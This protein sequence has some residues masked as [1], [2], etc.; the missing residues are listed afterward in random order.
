MPRIA[1]MPFSIFVLLIA[2]VQGCG[3]SP[4][5]FAVAERAPRS[6]KNAPFDPPATYPEWA[7]DQPRYMRPAEE[8]VPEPK[9]NANDPLHYFTK[10]KVVMVRKPEGYD[11]EESPRVALWWTDN[12]GFHWNKAGY[13]GRTQSY[14]PFEVEEDG[15]YG[16]RFV[17]P[18][19]DAAI[20]SLPYPERVYH[21]DTTLPELDV[22]IEPQQTWYTV[23]QAV[24]ISWRA[25]DYH[26][27]ETPV[28]IGMLLDFTH[29]GA[30][31][32]E[33]Q[34]DLAP[35]GS[36]RFTLPLETLD[37][38]VRF[39]A[40]ALDR[41]GNLGI[42]ISY[43]LQVVPDIAEQDEATDAA[44]GNEN[45][46][47]SQAW[48]AVGAEH[49]P[50]DDAYHPFRDRA[51]ESSLQTQTLESLLP[52]ATAAARLPSLDGG[53]AW[54]DEAADDSSL[55]EE[56]LESALVSADDPLTQEFDEFEDSQADDL[57]ANAA[58][59]CDP[60][61]P[62]AAIDEDDSPAEP[63]EALTVHPPRD[64]T[65]H[66]PPSPP[67][68]PYGRLQDADLM[69]AYALCA[70]AADGL[71][72]PMPATLSLDKDDL[73]LALAHPWRALCGPWPSEDESVW[74]LPRPRFTPQLDLLFEGSYLADQ[75]R[76]V[77]MSEPGRVES[78][79]AGMPS[80]TAPEQGVV[81]VP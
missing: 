74:L 66:D 3:E 43:A 52:S 47:V 4:P 56:S 70:A 16:I 18:G 48:P 71:L 80:E 2:V 37:H 1:R 81:D 39:R 28:R 26:L 68:S 53:L 75:R 32:V 76:V 69:R 22:A 42:A 44:A 62:I 10:E 11:A 8:L 79:F 29:D 65:P 35:E 12:N 51:H 49:A 5:P 20:H 17:G 33:V 55:E 73:T 13:F 78:A 46:A 54:T 36:F 7:Y 38:E 60:I 21:V 50:A 64:V 72:I 63:T 34:R 24:T 9:I 25:S 31:A 19:Q 58:P 6:D 45:D 57:A 61:Q 15:D 40:D 30:D 59:E 77:P 67:V 27:T 14:F 23:G 41:A